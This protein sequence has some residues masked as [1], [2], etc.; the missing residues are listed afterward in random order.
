MKYE[1]DADILVALG[2]SEASPQ[3]VEGSIRPVGF[4]VFKEFPAEVYPQS[5]RRPRNLGIVV[6]SKP[7]DATYL[8]REY[9]HP[10]EVYFIILLAQKALVTGKVDASGCL[11]CDSFCFQSSIVFLNGRLTRNDVCIQYLA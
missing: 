3:E 4:G 7:N 8:L 2:G 11:L 1:V 10:V 6:G 5:V 9:Y